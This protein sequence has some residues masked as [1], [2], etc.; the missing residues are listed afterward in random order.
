MQCFLNSAMMTIYSKLGSIIK[1]HCTNRW[2]TR[3]CKIMCSII[4]G[5][6]ETLRFRRPVFGLCRAFNL[7]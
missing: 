6:D 7:E 2:E 5:F 4:I 1:Y 3:S